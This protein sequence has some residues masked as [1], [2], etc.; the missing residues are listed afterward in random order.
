M[1]YLDPISQPELP[2]LPLSVTPEPIDDGKNAV[3]DLLDV[4]LV[5]VVACLA[6]FFGGGGAAAVFLI[7]HRAQG[8]TPQNL[9]KALEHNAFFLVSTQLVIYVFLVGFMSYLVWIRHRTSLGHAIR[10]NIPGR[11]QAA[12]ALALGFGL[13]LFSDLAEAVLQRWIPKSLPI[14]ELFRDRSSALLLA[15]FGIL[16]APLV[17]EVL[18][19]GFLYPALARWTGVAPSVLVTAAA[20]ALLHGTQLAYSWAPLLLIFIVGVAL[21]ITRA[22]TKSVATCVLV[23]MAYNFTLLLQAYIGTHGFR[24]MQG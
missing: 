23:H 20:F 12:Y 9:S 14:E 5:L 15:A 1:H 7:A 2:P 4:L 13:A 8:V 6:Y 3:V 10:W 16:I 22:A 11:R 19:R 21:T 24:Q 17:E 18:F